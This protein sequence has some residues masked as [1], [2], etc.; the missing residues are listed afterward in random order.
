MRNAVACKNVF[1][2]FA[3]GFNVTNDDGNLARA[4]STL[5]QIRDIRG[6]CLDFAVAAGCLDDPQ[7]II[8][9]KRLVRIEYKQLFQY[10]PVRT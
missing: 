1:Q 10:G 9:R 6:D 4:F 3:V 7:R 2:H 5:E 8:R